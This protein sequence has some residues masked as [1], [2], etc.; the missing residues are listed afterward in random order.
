MNDKNLKTQE[1]IDLSKLVDKDR[2]SRAVVCS[3]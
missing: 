3:I 2:Y 1:F